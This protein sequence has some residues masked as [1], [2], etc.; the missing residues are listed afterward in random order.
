VWR[1]T[2]SQRKENFSYD[3]PASLRYC[4]RPLAKLKNLTLRS[5]S[6]QRVKREV[7][8]TPKILRILRVLGVRK[9]P[10]RHRIKKF[11]YNTSH[12][13][14]PKAA[15]GLCKMLQNNALS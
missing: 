6:A 3:W 9:A 14:P 13:N 11:V 15:F 12:V 2:G 4:H 10:F 7:G 8:P 1:E 5:A